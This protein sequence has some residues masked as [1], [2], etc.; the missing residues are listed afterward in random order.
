MPFVRGHA[1]LGLG[2]L[3][4]RRQLGQR[5]RPI[6][7]VRARHVAIGAAGLELVILEPQRR[8]GPVH[9]RAADRLDD[10]GRQVR[11][12]MRDPPGAGRGSHVLPGELGEAFP[13]VVDEIRDLVAVA[14]LEDDDLDALLRQ[15]VAERAAPRR[16]SRRCRRRCRRSDRIVPCAWS[17][18]G[19]RQPVDV[20]E[21]AMEVAAM[22]GGGPLVAKLR[23]QRRLVVERHDESLRA[24]LKNGVCSMPLQQ[25]HPVGLPGDGEVV[26]AVGVPWRRRRAGRCR[27]SSARGRLGPWRP[28][29]PRAG[30]RR[31][32]RSRRYGRAGRCR[33]TS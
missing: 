5:D 20:V 25:D 33:G 14:R 23:P 29:R 18:S 32:R 8:A 9:G 17:L 24:C 16:R 27:R 28:S 15:F 3:V 10:P 7:Q 2:L 4:P 6:Q 30:R 19:G 13:L 11:E 12:I 1:H 26:G 22:L 31:R 21:A